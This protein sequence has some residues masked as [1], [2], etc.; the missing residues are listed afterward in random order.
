MS[1]TRRVENV[2]GLEHVLTGFCAGS[3]TRGIVIRYIL[4]YR[5][6]LQE[7]HFA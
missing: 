5:N 6:R 1:I 7:N 2:N 4:N 3:T